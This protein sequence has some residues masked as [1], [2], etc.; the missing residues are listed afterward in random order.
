[1]QC[2]GAMAVTAH[3]TA[4]HAC[5][6]GARWCDRA[7]YNVSCAVQ[8][9]QCSMHGTHARQAL[10]LTS[11]PH[12]ATSRSHMK[13]A[14]S[15]SSSFKLS[16]TLQAS[17]CSTSAAVVAL[18]MARQ[19]LC[20]RLATPRCQR[21]VMHGCQQAARRWC[22]GMVRVSCLTSQLRRAVVVA[23]V[24]CVCFRHQASQQPCHMTGSCRCCRWNSDTALAGRN[25][26]VDLQKR[27]FWQD[28]PPSAVVLPGSVLLNVVE[29]YFKTKQLPVPRS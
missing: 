24:S 13:R 21:C 14:L 29:A 23:H 6:A 25:P 17:C 18:S 10:N 5:T 26:G 4:R 2:C 1:M 12:I 7:S 27:N 15:N 8:H 9:V 28:I 16:C 3:H 20:T 19:P 11:L 22:N